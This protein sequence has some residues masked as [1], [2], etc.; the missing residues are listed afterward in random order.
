MS[1]QRPVYCWDT[2]V[3]LAH[4]KQESDKP[5]D[6][7]LAVA[8]EIESD[9]AE[10]IVSITTKME[11]LDVVEDE[12]LAKALTKFLDRRNV[13]LVD[14]NPPVAD[15]ALQIRY[16]A[17]KAKPNPKNVKVADAQ[18][19]ATAIAYGADVLHTFDEKILKLDK[20]SIVDELS[21][22]RPCLLSGQKLLRYARGSALKPWP[23]HFQRNGAV[24]TFGRL[25]S[26]LEVAHHAR[27]LGHR[28]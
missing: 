17:N 19:V 18:I 5:L 1:N 15:I 27:S 3:F 16:K 9:K 8:N 23:N 11:I 26:A 21:I 20:S 10:L 14:V 2:C 4:L 7:I 24:H 22:R 12:S 28:Q 6:D 13:M 25:H